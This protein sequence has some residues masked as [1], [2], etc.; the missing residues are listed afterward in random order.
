MIAFPYFGGKGGVAPDI[1]QRF[2]NPDHYY[3]PFAG[4]LGVLLARPKPGKYESVGDADGFVTNFWRAARRSPD[5]V[6]FWSD[7]PPNSLDLLARIRWLRQQKSLVAD[8]V[9]DPD[10]Y[11]AKVAGWWAWCQSTAIPANMGDRLQL[12]SSSGIHRERQRNSLYGY[13]RA[14]SERLDRVTVYHGDWTRLAGS[15]LAS[16]RHGG[17]VAVLLDPPYTSKAGRRANLYAHD[18]LKV[19]SY[20]QRWALAAASPRLKVALCGYAGEYDMPSAWEEMRW[21]SNSGKGRERI[22]FSP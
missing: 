18:S 20:V 2:G 17:T 11:D 19:G 12:G 1:W 10:G 21:Q 5:E 15:A 8:L 13:C 22:W 3:E 6:A 7:D 4:G 16:A 14:L 9:S